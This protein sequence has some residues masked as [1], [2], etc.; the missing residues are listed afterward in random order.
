MTRSDASM[1]GRT[2][3]PRF[4]EQHTLCIR[5]IQ[6]R[7]AAWYQ[8][9]CRPLPWRETGNPYLIWVSEVM[10]QQ[11]QVQT[12]IPYYRRF[13]R[14]FPDIRTL[15]GA[16]L[17]DVL[18]QWEGLG[19]YGR[20]R[21]LHQAAR[22]VVDQHGGI[23]PETPED[24]R[25]LKGVGEYIAAAVASIAFG[26]PLAVVDGNVKR[27]L[28]RLY[29][30]DAPVNRSS[31]HKIFRQAADRLLDTAD[32]AAFNQAM[33]ELGALV[34]RPGKPV[35]RDCPIHRFCRAFQAGTVDR[36]PQRVR[37]PKIPEYP[38]AVGVVRK[39]GRVLITRRK[40]EGL[41]G[42]LW[43]FPGGKIKKGETPEAACVREIAEETGLC[44]HVDAHLTRVRHA[45][46][47]FRILLDVF[48]CRYASGRV[49]LN[50]PDDYRWIK[51]GDTDRYPFPGAN[52]KFIPLLLRH[53]G[54]SE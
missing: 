34:C 40:P 22:T 39:N 3:G 14:R 6:R 46:T 53:M 52:H 36:F 18:K 51:P 31:S 50:G 45:Y 17:E 11:T 1:P 5:Q 33:M 48:V 12:V 37:S 2:N 13:I 4:M 9:H 21:N 54:L 7:L 27:L 38:I 23:I 35:C 28:A 26:R 47:H 24:F 43:E 10:L 30:I 15:A 20:A 16:G 29:A 49:R 44:V 41:L 19:Y 32:P 25:R 8:D 42:G